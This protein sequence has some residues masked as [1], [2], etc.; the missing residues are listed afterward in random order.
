MLSPP[1]MLPSPGGVPTPPFATEL[2]SDLEHLISSNFRKDL[3]G[4]PFTHLW[5][6]PT[7]LSWEQPQGS[8]ASALLMLWAGSVSAVGGRPEH[9]WIFNS[10]PGL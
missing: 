6:Q 9:C 8:S 3:E 10:I 4:D 1:A 5:S 7:R 2:L